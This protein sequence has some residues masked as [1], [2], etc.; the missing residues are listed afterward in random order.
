MEMG[1]AGGEVASG[2]GGNGD[3][4]EMAFKLVS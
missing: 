4:A 1:T 2:R 3:W